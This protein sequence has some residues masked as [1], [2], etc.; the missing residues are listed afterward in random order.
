MWG[1]CKSS[2]QLA[3]FEAWQYLA[4]FVLNAFLYDLVFQKEQMSVHAH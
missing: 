4:L 2:E 1:H 3:V